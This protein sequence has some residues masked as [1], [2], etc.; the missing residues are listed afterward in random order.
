[1]QTLTLLYCKKQYAKLEVLLLNKNSQFKWTMQNI[2]ELMR[3]YSFARI[4][5]SLVIDLRIYSS[6]L[7]TINIYGG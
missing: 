1:M 6:D 4:I 5:T 7:N 2:I 3:Y